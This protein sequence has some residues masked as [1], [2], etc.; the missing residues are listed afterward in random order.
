MKQSQPNMMSDT[1]RRTI[2]RAIDGELSA[3]EQLELDRT[4]ISHPE[5]HREHDELRRIDTL[6]GDSLRHAYAQPASANPVP[7]LPP[8]WLV[9]VSWALAATVMLAIGLTWWAYSPADKTQS[10][11]TSTV[12]AAANN[13]TPDNLAP[14]VTVA[15]TPIQTATR[16][17]TVEP[18]Y[19]AVYDEAH[20][21]VYFYQVQREQS[22]IQTVAMDL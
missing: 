7:L 18:G 14:S 22:S 4:L 8:R 9:G 5:L 21:S 17:R 13:Q 1:Q 3:G 6:A 12:I 10:V 19:V 20:K 11:P 16:R 15:D 2:D